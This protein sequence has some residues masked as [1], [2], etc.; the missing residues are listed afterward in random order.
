MMAAAVLGAA[1]LGA[2]AQMHG[3]SKASKAQQ[4]AAREAMAFQMQMAERAQNALSPYLNVGRFGAEQLQ[5]NLP[6]ST[7][8]IQMLDQQG[9]ENLP[10]YQ[11]TRDQGLKAVQAGAAARGLGNSGTAMKGAERFAAG[12][13]DQ[14]YG[15]QFDRYFNLENTNRANAFNRP[16]AVAGMGANAAGQLAGVL[17]GTGQG[18]SNNMIGIGNAQ[19]AAAMAQGNAIAGAANSVMGYGMQQQMMRPQG[20]PQQG[21]YGSQNSFY[22]GSPAGAPAG[23]GNWTY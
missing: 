20:M 11:F 22:G 19:G 8:Q 3:A 4:A 12:L 15:N 7:S 2:G 21:M 16:F 18:V 5:A 23:Y 10:G 17:T 14:T 6:Y 13:A 1:A 9:L